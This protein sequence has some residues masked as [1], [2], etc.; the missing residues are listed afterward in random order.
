MRDYPTVH[1]RH[2]LKKGTEIV[3]LFYISVT[4]ESSIMSISHTL[5]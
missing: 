3:L 2:K 1:I 5:K 4:V